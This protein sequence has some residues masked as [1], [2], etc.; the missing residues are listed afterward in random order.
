MLVG[1]IAHHQER[2]EINQ[3]GS[4]LIKLKVNDS[5]YNKFVASLRALTA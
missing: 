2:F 5:L 1:L 4:E 3:E